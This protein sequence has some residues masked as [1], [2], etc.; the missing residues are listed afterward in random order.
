MIYFGSLIEVN[1]VIYLRKNSINKLNT[2][3]GAHK[4]KIKDRLK[5]I[6]YKKRYA[7]YFII[8]SIALY[9]ICLLLLSGI[10]K[11]LLIFYYLT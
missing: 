3:I 10:I 9:I 8:V 5:A 11:C 2:L 7:N 6:K 1:L 4:D